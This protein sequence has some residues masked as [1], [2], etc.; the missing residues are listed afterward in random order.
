MGP[1]GGP[2][3][4]CA[5]GTSASI[6]RIGGGKGCGDGRNSPCLASASSILV[7]DGVPY[8]A[9]LAVDGLL[10]NFMHTNLE[11]VIQWFM[12]DLESERRIV[13]VKIY[14][15]T[16]NGNGADRMAG[17]EIRVGNNLTWDGNQICAS[18]LPGI[19]II[20]VQCNAI[21]RYVFVVQPRYEVLN[22][23]EIE[24]LSLTSGSCVACPAGTSVS[25]ERIGGGKGCGD[26]GNSPCLASASS[27]YMDWYP[28]AFALDWKLDTHMHT[29][30]APNEWFMLD[31]ESERRIVSVT[32]NARLISGESCCADR[33]VGAQIRVGNNKSW[34]GNQ[35]C[36]SNLPG[37]AVIDVECNAVGRYVFV[38]QPRS[39]VPL[40]FAEI[41]VLTSGRRS[42]VI[43]ALGSGAPQQSCDDVCFSIGRSCSLDDIRNLNSEQAV[44]GVLSQ[45]GHSIPSNA[46]WETGDCIDSG[47]GWNANI[48]FIADN[49]YF[50]CPG[51]ASSKT[52][53]AAKAPYRERICACGV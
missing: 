15:R 31:L 24:V 7:H 43:Y 28:A 1:D 45:L 47:G 10:D 33:M 2:C 50:Y 19:D 48:P 16:F 41:E 17:A 9:A 14:S 37:N 44:R 29:E 49:K 35:I 51:A 20:D 22:F 32:I 25:M 11:T 27:N 46:E 12:L 40:N 52:L 30:I 53:C 34:D 21:G 39:D 18:Q 6:E 13:S 42:C 4:A 36:A 8:P 3:V 5:A 26:G 38:V 23:A